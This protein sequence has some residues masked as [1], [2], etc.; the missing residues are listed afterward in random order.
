[1]QAMKMQLLILPL[2]AILSLGCDTWRSIDR[3]APIASIPPRDTV[4][5]S[6][7]AIPGVQRV[8]YCAP[9]NP[10]DPLYYA[11]WYRTKN[12]AFSVAFR[13]PDKSQNVID[14]QTGWF[15]HAPDAQEREAA[16]EMMDT[17]YFTLKINCPAIPP[18]SQFRESTIG[19]PN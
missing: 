15:N 18:H 17:V 6:L 9:A 4:E 19:L 11:I 7:L 16:R 14:I 1:M 5:R 12:A 2:L 8:Q 10:N 13:N 3:T